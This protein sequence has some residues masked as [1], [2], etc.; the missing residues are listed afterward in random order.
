V[1][2]D[3]EM[4]RFIRASLNNYYNVEEAKD[5][6][7]GIQKAQ[8]ILPDLIVSDI[9]MP[10][11]D[12][13]ELCQTL[14][15]DINTS[16]IPIILLTAKASE[17]SMIEGLEA[18]ADDYITKPFNTKMLLSRIKNLVDLRTQLQEKIQRQMMLQPVE[19]KVSS[20]DQRFI[21][22]LQEIIEKHISDETL[23]VETL[24]EKMGISRVT[25]NK[26]IHAL[27]GE[28]AVD[29]IRS[30]RLKRAMQ[31]LKKNFG[32]ILDVALEVG[33]SSSAYFTK[34]F[35]EKFHQL[36]SDLI[37]TVNNSKKSPQKITAK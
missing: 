31:L 2:D 13:I 27:T 7:G 10:N 37:D 17:S 29:Y 22:Q 12:G 5:G 14:K 4:R 23:N 36:P 21:Q 19:I 25:L 24:S 34:C 8:N 16:H 20:F 1:E 3:R 15:T 35:K 26:K 6:R 32:S 33:F 11:T 28:T 18:G 9:M 30:F